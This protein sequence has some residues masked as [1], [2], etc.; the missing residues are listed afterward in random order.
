MADQL[1][2]TDGKGGRWRKRRSGSKQIVV[3]DMQEESSGENEVTGAG[4]NSTLIDDQPKE[5]EIATKG[6][7]V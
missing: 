1:Y 3:G 7:V 2:T 6:H 4:T 5:F